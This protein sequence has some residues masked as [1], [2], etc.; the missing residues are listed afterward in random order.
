MDA[1]DRVLNLSATGWAA[2]GS[3]VGAAS[4][5]VL[6][7]FNGLF[8]KAAVR[9]ANAASEQA[10]S[11]NEQAIAATAA[12]RLTSESNQIERDSLQQQQRPWVGLDEFA[13]SMGL[14]LAYS[15]GFATGPVSVG[16]VSIDTNGAA[17]A[18]WTVRVKN[19][20]EG[21]AQ[22][23]LV[24]AS[25]MVTED[26]SDIEAE[27]QG[28]TRPN[29]DRSIG[30]LLFPG[31]TAATSSASTFPSARMKSATYDHLFEIWFVGVIHYWDR[32]GNHYYTGFRYWMVE[33]DK[34]RPFRFS[35][36]PNSTAKNPFWPQASGGFVK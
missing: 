33:P 1:A 2:I 9:S 24:K 28:L 15:P 17:F 29:Q 34:R 19:F 12:I 25:L 32:F 16:E 18:E 5:L 31:M 10:K 6:S 7:I 8:L 26:L 14:V 23:V 11:A 3:I 20:G 13:P 22:S 35:A 36:Q 27:Q 21:P 4:V 30:T